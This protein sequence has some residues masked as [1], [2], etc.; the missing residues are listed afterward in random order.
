MV[1]ILVSGYEAIACMVGWFIY[2]LNLVAECFTILL[3]W[4]LLIIINICLYYKI[5]KNYFI[6]II[7]TFK[8]KNI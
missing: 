1:S 5:Y 6:F 2:S 7:Y 3:T 8:N 4:K